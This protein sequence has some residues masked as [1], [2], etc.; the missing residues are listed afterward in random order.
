MINTKPEERATAAARDF[1]RAINELG[2]DAETFAQE[3]RREHR[4]LQQGAMRVF[5]VLLRQWARDY[6][7]ENF[8]LRNMETVKAADTILKD[9]VD[10]YLPHI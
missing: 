5:V 4:T 7:N 2:F 8:D 10:I 9:A 1:M 6:Q 3:V